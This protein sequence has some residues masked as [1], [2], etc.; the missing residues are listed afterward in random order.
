[1]HSSYGSCGPSC[2]CN[3]SSKAPTMEDVMGAGCGEEA[4]R[5]RTSNS[6][7][8]SQQTPRK[9]PRTAA[10]VEWVND[11]DTQK[12]WWAQSVETEATKCAASH[13]LLQTQTFL[14]CDVGAVP[15]GH[16][17]S[18]RIKKKSQGSTASWAESTPKPKLKLEVRVDGWSRQLK[19]FCLLGNMKGFR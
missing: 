4:G 18:M 10:H 8:R 12:E 9:Q 7:S 13:V 6:M 15:S 1:M 3:R 5:R 11:D 14:P 16:R 2:Y 17:L 19:R